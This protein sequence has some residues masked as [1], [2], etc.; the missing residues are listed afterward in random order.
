M[1]TRARPKCGGWIIKGRGRPACLPKQNLEIA[2]KEN[3]DEKDL[4]FLNDDGLE[5]RPD[6]ADGSHL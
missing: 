1:A 6:G 2:L 5:R 3:N 4:V